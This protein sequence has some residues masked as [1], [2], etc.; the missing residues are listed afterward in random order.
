MID[1][2]FETIIQVLGV[3]LLSPLYVGILE[4]IKALIEG[5]RGP[6]IFQPYFDL[7]KLSKKEMSIPRNAGWLFINGPFI[8]FS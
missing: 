2:L 3:I 1:V 8:V 6:S 7:L 5:R 4:R